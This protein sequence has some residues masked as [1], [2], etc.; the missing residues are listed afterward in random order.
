MEKC[1]LCDDPDGPLCQRCYDEAMHGIAKA[2][3]GG[4]VTFP[5]SISCPLEEEKQ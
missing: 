5:D 2:V 1:R 3:V 4:K